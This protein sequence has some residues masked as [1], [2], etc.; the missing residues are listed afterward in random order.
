M[1]NNGHLKAMNSKTYLTADYFVDKLR[2]ECQEIYIKIF[3]KIKYLVNT[4]IYLCRYFDFLFSPES[5]HIYT[6]QPQSPIEIELALWP[7]TNKQKLIS[8]INKIL[9]LLQ[10]LVKA[11]SV[12]II[13]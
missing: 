9:L 11:Y 4:Y 13:S 8:N 7:S 5:W 3:R 2:Q 12:F 10:Y 6:N 1:K